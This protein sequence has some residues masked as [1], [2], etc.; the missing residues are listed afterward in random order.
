[1]ESSK[2]IEMPQQNPDELLCHQRS[3]IRNID[4][5][6]AQLLAE[7]FSVVEVIAN[8]KRENNI[9]LMQPAQWNTVEQNY[10]QHAL[11]ASCF[12]E[13]LEKYLKL[14]HQYSLKMQQSQ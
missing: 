10:T 2:Q 13:F 4:K 1:M 9:P 3:L 5:Q 8:I 6:I 7:R 12:T 11:D 14:L